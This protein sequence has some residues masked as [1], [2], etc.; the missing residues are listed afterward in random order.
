MFG[1]KTIEW[2][3]LEAMAQNMHSAS[4][5]TGAWLKLVY[6]LPRTDAAHPR[7]W[8][9]SSHLLRVVRPDFYAEAGGGAHSLTEQQAQGALSTLL[10][11]HVSYLDL[12]SVVVAEHDISR[13]DAQHWVAVFQS[14]IFSHALTTLGVLSKCAE[15]LCSPRRIPYLSALRVPHRVR[16]AGVRASSWEVGLWLGTGYADLVS[17]ATRSPANSISLKELL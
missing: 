13:P 17:R 3:G 6:Q 7:Q 9:K 5:Q 14:R 10:D 15:G 8:T 2:F 12:P 16:R 11:L 4:A 1:L